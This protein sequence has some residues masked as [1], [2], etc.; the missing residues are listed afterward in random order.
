MKLPNTRAAQWRVL[1]AV[2]D[3]GGY[4]QAALAL[5]RSQSSIS[6]S[7]AQ[8]Q[9]QV[10]LP[11]LEADGRRMRLTAAGESLLADA[12]RLLDGF[13]R[14]EARAVALR[15]GWEGEVRLAVDSLFP[16]GALMPVLTA[17]AA[18]CPET[19]LQLHEVVMSGADQALYGGKVDLAVATRVP[20]GFL[21]DWL[22]EVEFRAVAAPGHPLVAAGRPLQ[23]DDLVGHTQIVVRDSGEQE[24]RD[25]GWL[26]ARQRWTVSRVET[27]LALLRAGLGYAWLPAHAIGRSLA[28]GE[29]VPLPLS[30]GASRPM[31]LYLILADPAGTGPAAQRLFALFKQN[32]GQVPG[33]G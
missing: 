1:Q 20:P 21:G 4:A 14:L 33:A 11:L 27:S 28:A 10:G 13:D 2:V 16:T 23:L 19:R 29:L 30:S 3:C 25:A 12:R 15:G 8:L 26:G 32:A 7:L 24:P 9:R 22:C 17:F 18:A 5:H 6:Y 31:A